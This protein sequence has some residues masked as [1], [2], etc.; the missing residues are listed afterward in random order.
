MPRS[1]PGAAH[2]KL[3]YNPIMSRIGATFCANIVLV[4]VIAGSAALDTIASYRS[5]EGSAV[6]DAPTTAAPTAAALPP[7]RSADGAPAVP[8]Y[9]IETLRG[10]VVWMASALRRRFGIESDEDAAES[11][12][13]LEATDG[14]LYPLVKDFHGRGFWLDPRLRDIDVEIAARRYDKSPAVQIVRWYAIKEGRKYEVDYWCDVCAIPMYELK[15]CE[16]C[17]GETRLRE[18]LVTKTDP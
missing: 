12:A 6:A 17:Q 5:D 1:D 18:R 15:A 3:V 2:P 7:A 16:C 13:A 14:I 10:R 11:T 9:R 4:G 8:A